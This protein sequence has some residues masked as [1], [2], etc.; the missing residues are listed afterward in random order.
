MMVNRETKEPVNLYVDLRTKDTI[1]GATGEVVNGYIIKTNNGKYEYDDD[2]KRKV[3]EDEAKIK[4]DD[5]KIKT[6]DE[7]R[8]EKDDN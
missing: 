3:E 1:H 4:T 7:E 8:K 5:K 2:Y 6:D